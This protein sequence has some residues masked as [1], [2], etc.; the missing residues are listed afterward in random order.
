MP[1]RVPKPKKIFK[2]LTIAVAGTLKKGVTNAQIETWVTLRAGKFSHG[3][4][5]SVTHLV[6]SEEDWKGR[7]PMGR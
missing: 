1:R 4:N 6:C 7:S 2:N 5:D 3:M